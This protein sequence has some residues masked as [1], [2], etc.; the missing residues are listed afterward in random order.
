LSDSIPTIYVRVDRDDKTW[1]EQFALKHKAQGWSQNHVISRLLKFV[2]QIP[3]EELHEIIEGTSSGVLTKAS[4]LME[5][6]AWLQ[7]AFGQRFWYWALELALDLEKEAAASGAIDMEKFAQYRIAY[8]WLD[9][10]I[11]LR[12]GTIRLCQSAKNDWI[13][14]FSAADWALCAS[15][16]YN[17]KYSIGRIQSRKSP[18]VQ[19]PL[20]AFNLACAWSLRAQYYIE[21]WLGP[22]AK[23]IKAISEKLT[24]ER[25]Q[26]LASEKERQFHAGWR[27]DLVRQNSKLAEAVESEVEWRAEQ[28]LQMLELLKIGKFSEAPTDRE[29]IVRFAKRDSD[30]ELLRSDEGF[31]GVFEAWAGDSSEHKISL[32]ESFQKAKARISDDMVKAIHALKPDAG[33][34]QR[35]RRRVRS[36]DGTAQE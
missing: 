14:L 30:L 17:E 13:E 26:Q 3:D 31:K 2:Q 35:P 4:S 21:R 22:D 6:F 32:L 29:F 15:I 28:S 7:Q 24:K 10:A 11:E 9:I 23:P 27:A 19:H 8:C 16:A 18:E 25:D 33:R 20:V 1:L 34:D 12:N 36:T 5:Q